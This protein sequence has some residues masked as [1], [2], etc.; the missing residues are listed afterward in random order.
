MD[1]ETVTVLKLHMSAFL[2]YVGSQSCVGDP[3]SPV[4]SALSWMM[5]N[6]AI[7]FTPSYDNTSSAY[8]NNNR[9]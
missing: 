9:G 5:L 8:Q 1:P 6:K 4:L 3:P 7:L 2:S